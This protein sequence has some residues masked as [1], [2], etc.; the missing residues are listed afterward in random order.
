MTFPV[1]L[2]A[3]QVTAWHAL[4]RI[5]PSNGQV[6]TNVRTAHYHRTLGLLDAP[7]EGGGKGFGE[8]HF[9]YACA[10]RLLQSERLPL[11]RIQSLL[12][13]RSDEELV[14][15]LT[16]TDTLVDEAVCYSLAAPEGV[17]FLPCGVR[18]ETGP[19]TVLPRPI[20][21]L[22]ERHRF[23]YGYFYATEDDLTTPLARWAH[24]FD[25]FDRLLTERTLLPE[26]VTR[27]ITLMLRHWAL[28]TQGTQRQHTVE[29]WLA[30]L[31]TA[32][33]LPPS[34]PRHLSRRRTCPD[35]QGRHRTPRNR[36]R[37]SR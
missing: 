2:L 21:K 9:L 1:D 19:N 24:R 22:F 17:P 28:K 6:A 34:P 23:V 14:A 26:A 10:V 33:R 4:H 27:L 5:V 35:P 31:V 30:E 37:T 18:G 36:T 32:S 11:T 15:E 8:R 29:N 12:F 13:G 3:D 7:T 20:R 25:R 16:P